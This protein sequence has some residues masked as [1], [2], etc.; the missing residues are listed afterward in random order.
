MATS[1]DQIKQRYPIPVYNYRV[2]IVMGQV[3]TLSEFAQISIPEDKLH[4]IGCSAVLGLNM[5][6]E[7]VEYRHG[8]SFFSGQQLVSAGSKPVRL[9]ILKG[10]TI[11]GSY[12]SDWMQS[13]QSDK[14]TI[15]ID[16][17]NERGDPVIR[18]GVF[19][20]LPLSLEAPAFDANSSEAAFE[21]LDVVAQKMEVNYL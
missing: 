7:V 10:V 4:R 11:K 2:T 21:R 18:W 6:N 9:S 3:S 5:E 16:L 1:T 12:L 20:A 14:R 15:I 13:P 17:C 19:H 8:Y